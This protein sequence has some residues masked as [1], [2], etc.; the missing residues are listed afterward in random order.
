[1][2]KFFGILFIII[3]L[4]MLIGGIAAGASGAT[5]A[6]TN[7][8]QV[9]D[10]VGASNHEGTAI[11]GAAVAVVGLILLIVGIAMT[12]SKS[13]SQRKKEAEL[14]VL[15]NMNNNQSSFNN[16]QTNSQNSVLFDEL[17]KQS[18]KMYAQ[19]D[20]SAAI[21]IIRRMLEIN[22]KDSNSYFNMACCLSLSENKEGL[23]ALSKA[24]E[25]GYSNIEKVKS[26]EALAW[27][28]QLTE[29]DEF[30]RSGFKY[31]MN[32]S[33][34]STATAAPIKPANE[35]AINDQMIAQLEKLGKL[36]EQGLINDEE[37]QQQKKKILG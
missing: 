31:S 7:Y 4:I 20:Y 1:M 17:A 33:R 11:G 12:A 6:S 5:S 35:G 10:F 2:K 34:N 18:H 27:L 14:S 26:Y 25:Y 30:L 8:G 29:Y 19:K 22:P 9:E 16:N 23:E 36:K 32:S 21:G 13:S 24:V 15:R 37:F 28:R 3:G